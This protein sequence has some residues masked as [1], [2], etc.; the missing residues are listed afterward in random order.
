MALYRDLIDQAALLA[1]REPRRPKQ[2]SLRRAVSTAY[3]GVFHL[4]VSAAVKQL[5]GTDAPMASLASRAFK[6][7]EMKDVAKSFASG[8][9]NSRVSDI[10]AA[11]DLPDD[12]KQV[13]SAFVE[14]QEARHEADYDLA[15]RFV[16]SEVNDLLDLA[17]QAIGA[18]DRDRMTREARVFL[19]CLLVQKRLPGR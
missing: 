11:S 17:A 13:A 9:L 5:V 4:L 18:W 16:R 3:Y 2:A 19:L 1:R 12:L 15:R 8:V 7:H 6:H 14:L 10:V